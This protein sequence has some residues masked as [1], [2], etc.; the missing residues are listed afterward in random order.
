MFPDRVGETQLPH[1]LRFAPPPC[2][3]LGIVKL[4]QPSKSY[5]LSDTDLVPGEVLEHRAD[6]AIP[7]GQGDLFQIDA[8]D[9]DATDVGS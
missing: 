5:V 7:V 3:G 9:Y 6:P 2:N 1:P 4:W 8:I